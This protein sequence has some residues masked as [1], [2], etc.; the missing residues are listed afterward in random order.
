MPFP[1]G[2]QTVTV[3]K[4]YRR[5]DGTAPSLVKIWFRP[6]VRSVH[7]GPDYTIEPVPVFEQITNGLLSTVL[8]ATVGFSYEVTELVDGKQRA[9][10]NILVPTG[11]S[12]VSLDSLAPVEPVIPNYVPVRTVEGIG[13]DPAGNIDL[14]ASGGSAPSTR[15]INTTGGVVGGG[16]LSADRTL[17]LT[18]GS[19]A[20]TVTQGNDSRLSNARTPL[21]HT[22]VVADTTGLQG[23]L[24]GKET[25]GTATTAVNAHIAVS[26][27]H[28][29]YLTP[30]EGN[31]A[32]ETVGTATAAVA[33][34]VGLP[35]PHPQYLT[36]AEGNASYSV[37]GHTHTTGDVTGLSGA[38]A[39]KAT[40]LVC[41]EAYVT[42]GNTN[43]NT[44]SGAWGAL[45]GFSTLSIPAAVGDKIG[46]GG[47]M[48]RQP[49]SN[50]LADVGVVVGGVVRRWLGGPFT[51]SSPPSGTYEGDMALYH[52]GGIPA[53]SGERRFTVT[54]NDLDSGNVVFA[55]LCKVNGGGSALILADGNTPFYWQ[56]TNYGVTS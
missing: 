12:T 49:N 14:P 26:D 33:T 17:S 39:T 2:A 6:S 42:S 45:P 41:R 52:T 30:A 19:S 43:L 20:N 28:P 51:D 3:T 15:L 13:P 38:L 22:H 32:Y 31:A 55:M 8:F 56:A 18:Y 29:Q 37:L 4:D 25:A 27:P 7:V 9:P 36:P 1:P 40:K 48:A 23:A 34:H 50:L 35:D 11:G 16:D 44:G 5:A 53:R 24:D 21:A 10:F 54:S 47:N 46:F